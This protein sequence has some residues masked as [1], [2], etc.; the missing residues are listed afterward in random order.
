MAGIFDAD[1]CELIHNG[2][3]HCIEG[4]CKEFVMS[5]LHFNAIDNTLLRKIC[6]NGSLEIKEMKRCQHFRKEYNIIQLSSLNK[7]L[8]DKLCKVNCFIKENDFKFLLSFRWCGAKKH[9]WFGMSI[10]PQN[11]HK[12]IPASPCF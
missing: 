8:G 5:T 6:D 3:I 11:S 1:C 4:H 9:G 2:S 10:Q 7:T 12:K